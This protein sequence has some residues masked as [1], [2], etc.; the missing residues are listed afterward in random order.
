[1]DSQLPVLIVGAGPSGLAMACALAHL[2]IPFR[3]LDKNNSPVEGS[4]ATW[5]QPRSLQFFHLLG[6]VDAFLKKGHHCQA[7]TLRV[8]GKPLGRIP[9][10]QNGSTYPYVIVLPQH[11]TE[12]LLLAHLEQR[13][14]KVERSVTLT[15]LSQS[16][17]AV[18]T[19]LRDA[20]GKEEQATFS[21]VVG[22]DG[23]ASTVRNLCQIAFPG[24][25]LPGQFVV[26]DTRMD[27][28]LS[29]HDMHVFFDR[30]TVC[31]IFPMGSRR[32]RIC[33]NL[34]QSHPRKIFTEMEVREVVAERT[35][36]N[37]NVESVS[38]ISPF[39][40]HSRQVDRMRA[41]RVFLVGDAAH[42]H[43]PAGGQGLNSGI[44]DA[45]NLAF[46]LAM[47]IRGEANEGLLESYQAER[48]PVVAETIAQS[49][50]FTR[51]V[52]SRVS[53]K[54]KWEA[55]IAPSPATFPGLIGRRIAQMDTRYPDSPAICLPGRKE[56]PSAPQPGDIA[57][58]IR[59]APGKSLYTE[60]QAMRHL[61]L[62]FEG[63]A[64]SAANTLQRQLEEQFGQAIKV[65]RVTHK[66]SD[67]PG[68]IA[69]PEGRLYA[70]YEVATMATYVIRPDAHIVACASGLHADSVTRVFEH[71]Q[72]GGETQ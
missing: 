72:Q 19:T 22:C 34:H 56:T 23:A 36:T 37:F 68:I 18:K 39:W 33:A 70:L 61:V 40:T 50:Y 24:A 25:E 1:M 62:L 29:P 55:L 63:Q 2:G 32:Y 16:D 45:A 65:I 15:H 5:L 28:F 41:G 27:S 35:D 42:I 14:G 26:A 57:P 60:L 4:N 48:H 46:K 7:L 51:L 10:D 12:K 66:A 8:R 47:V 53:I 38:W 17:T 69:D 21:W 67:E 20:S 52:Q 30:E 3:I 58:D 6:V 59:L 43:S 31:A 9:F 64:R 13:G 54:K 49:E 11:E 71:Y 44:Q